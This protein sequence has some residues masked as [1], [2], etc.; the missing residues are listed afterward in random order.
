MPPERHG[1]LFPLQSRCVGNPIEAAGWTDS[2]P[3]PRAQDLGA[4]APKIAVPT[5]TWVAPVW[6]A[7]G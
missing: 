1:T 4:R 7:A 5:R 2:G 6:I 3:V